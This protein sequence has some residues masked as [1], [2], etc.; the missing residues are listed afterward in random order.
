MK[1]TRLAPEHVP[2]YRDLMLHGYEH[3]PDAFTSTPQ[4]RAAMPLSW[5]A[6]RAADPEGKSV[7][8]GAFSGERLV[9]AVAIEFS[10]K[11]KTKHKVHLVGMYVLESWRGKGVGRRLVSAAIEHAIA[12]PGIS[13]VALTVT[14]GN[15]SAVALYESAGFRAFGVEPMAILTP[16]GYKGKVHMWRAVVG[17][18]GAA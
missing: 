12:S 7:A 8:F 15:E 2:Q 13:V 14:E 1:I 16:A 11:P 9:G 17:G 3:A 4:E 6:M 5:W 10:S 18:N